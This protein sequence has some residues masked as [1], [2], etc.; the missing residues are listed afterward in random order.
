MDRV[1]DIDKPITTVSAWQAFAAE[2]E[3]T[4]VEEAALEARYKQQYP[5]RPLVDGTSQPTPIYFYG[6]GPDGRKYPD[7]PPVGT[8]HFARWR[9]E[10]AAVEDPGGSGYYDE[11]NPK[12][13]DGRRIRP[14]YTTERHQSAREVNHFRW[15]K[16]TADSMN[17]VRAFPGPKATRIVHDEYLLNQDDFNELDNKQPKG[18]VGLNNRLDEDPKDIYPIGYKLLK[19]WSKV[20][21][22]AEWEDG[23]C[24]GA[25][26]HCSNALTKH[27]GWLPKRIRTAKAGLGADPQ[28]VI[29]NEVFHGNPD[30]AP[31]DEF[32]SPKKT[33][34]EDPGKITVLASS[35]H[36]HKTLQILSFTTLKSTLPSPEPETLNT[37]QAWLDARAARRWEYPVNKSETTRNL[38]VD[39]LPEML[40]ADINAEESTG[41]DLVQKVEGERMTAESCTVLRK[42]PKANESIDPEGSGIVEKQGAAEVCDESASRETKTTAHDVANEEREAIEATLEELSRK[43]ESSKQGGKPI[44]IY[45]AFRS[46]FLGVPVTQVLNH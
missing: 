27:L 26:P 45:S 38:D 9:H 25:D 8:L 2:A 3:K 37:R 44:V 1:S 34:S 32:V 40:P 19:H 39:G 36:S 46:R 35:A 4:M 7:D 33:W 20:N 18:L 10:L 31:K 13:L 6:P 15:E 21:G 28:D 16:V 43:P 11:E 22:H 12:I 29:W 14:T 23:N 17:H 24:L 5:P 42:D 30:A 41:D